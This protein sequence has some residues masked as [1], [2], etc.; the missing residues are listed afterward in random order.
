LNDVLL[1]DPMLMSNLV[2]VLP[3][4]ISQFHSRNKQIQKATHSSTWLAWQYRF[5]FGFLNQGI[6][7]N[8]FCILVLHH[9]LAC[10]TTFFKTGILNHFATQAYNSFPGS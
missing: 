4:V 3:S 8:W 9:L 2:R 6:G 1:R 5:F 10:R 7:K